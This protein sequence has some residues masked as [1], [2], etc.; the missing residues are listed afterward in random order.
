MHRRARSAPGS[1]G[2]S[3][4]TRRCRP[5]SGSRTWAPDNQEHPVF[6]IHR[7]FL[8]S[9][10]RFIGILI[11]HYGGAFPLWL[12]PVQVRVLPVSEQHRE[13]RPRARREARR[14]RG[15]PRRD[16]RARRDARQ[17]DPRRRA[18]EDPATSS[19]GASAS[20]TTRSP[21]ARA[22]TGRR[23]GRSRSCSASS[24]SSWRR[25]GDEL[26][27]RLR[28]RVPTAPAALLRLRLQSRGR[29][30]HLRSHE[31]RGFNRVERRERPLGNGAAACQRFLSFKERNSTVLK[32][33]TAW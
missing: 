8:G 32:R 14:R 13:A 30:P 4:S 21:S 2:R 23:R 22:A 18:R 15:L 31:L 12:A 11:E 25:R 10:E 20:P 1:S 16:R 7:A 6:V 29:Y 5:A 27:G 3:S 24:T 19:S 9:F 26:S 17:A 28:P 33:D